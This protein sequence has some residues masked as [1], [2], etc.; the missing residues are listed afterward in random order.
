MS[1]T[2]RVE[3]VAAQMHQV[4]RVTLELPAGSSVRDALER[5]ATP[6]ERLVNTQAHPANEPTPLADASAQILSPANTGQPQHIADSNVGIWGRRVT[7][8]TALNNDDRIEL[9]RPV[10]ADAKS[11]RLKRASEQGYRWQGRTRRA[12]TK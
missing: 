2:I 7:L 8:D 6:H 3:I 12:A 4:L 9:Y 11:A 1:A 5:V 10:I